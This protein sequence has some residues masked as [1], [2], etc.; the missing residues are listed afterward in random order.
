[1]CAAFVS[2]WMLQFSHSIKIAVVV[3][4]G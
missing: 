3:N 2:T 1:M 4:Y